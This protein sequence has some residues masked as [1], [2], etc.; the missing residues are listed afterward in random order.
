MYR[1]RMKRLSVS[2]IGL[3]LFACGSVLQGAELSVVDVF[4]P[5]DSTSSVVVAGTILNESTLGVTILV[6]I[7][8]RAGNV[9][10][11]T[12]TPSPTAD[13]T[14]LDDPWPSA[15]LFSIFDT[16]SP[17]FSST[18]N[19]AVD[20]NGLLLPELVTFTGNMVDF[21]II[22]S[23]GAVGTW[24]FRLSTSIGNS[25]WEALT[26]TLFDGTIT[27]AL[28]ECFNDP[29]CDDGTFCNGLE[30]CVSNSCVSGNDPCPGQLCDEVGNACVDCLIDADCSDGT[31]CNG[32]EVC[33]G[34]TCGAGGDPCSGQ[35]CD[36]TGDFCF[37]C[38]LDIDCNDSVF[39]N[40]QETCSSGFCVAGSDP[41]PNQI[42]DETNQVCN[43]CSF[44]SECNDGV[45]CNGLETCDTGSCIAGTDPCTGQLCDEG[46]QICLPDAAVIAVEDLTLGAGGTNTLVI[47]GGIAGDLTF[48]VTILVEL[49]SR[50]GNIGS[51]SYTP[52]PP[53]DIAQLGDP[54]PGVG[55][56][57]TFDA[58]SLG[59]STTLNGS[60]DDNGT[61]T[62]API[63]YNDLLSGFPL[64][65]SP[66]A[67][68]V[69]DV[70]LNTSVGDSSWVNITTTLNNGTI[71]VIPSVGLT[72]VSKAMPPAAVTNVEVFGE[73]NG[74]S[75]IGVTILLEISPRVGNTGS[76][77]FTPSPP[78]DI[79]QI[80][81]PWPG[82]GTFSPFDTDVPGF[83]D[84]LN[85]SVDDNGS[86][87]FGAVKFSSILTAFPIQATADAT[88]IW[89]IRLSTS[90]GDSN[91]E[92]LTTA[93]SHG[94]IEIRTDA[95]LV[96][97]ECDDLN[98]CTDDACV[99][100][101]CQNTNNTIA[102]DDGDQCTGGDICTLGICVG[103]PIA[104]GGS[105]DDGDLCTIADVC[106]GGTC[107]GSPK[108]C[109][110]LDDACNIGTCNP[111]TGVCEAININ[112][113]LNCDDG[114]LCTELDVCTLGVCAGTNLD[115]TSFDAECFVGVCNVSTGIC[116]ASQ[117][118]DGTVCDDAD[119][120][121]INDA[122]TAG[123]CAGTALD[124]SSLDDGCIVGTCNGTTGLCEAVAV[125][126]GDAC[127]DGNLCTVSDVCIGGVCGG[128]P[129]DCTAL[130]SGCSLGICNVSTGR[131]E[132]S[133]INDG[134]ICDDGFT[135]TSNDVCTNGFCTGTL[136]GT[137]G[138]D[139]ALVPANN[140]VLVD[141]VIQVDLVASSST[142]SDQPAAS[143]EII[144]AWNPAFL[145]LVGKTDRFD[146]VWN[147]SKFPD[148]SQLDG[149]N[150]PFGDVPGNDGDAYYLA[151][152]GFTLNEAAFLTEAGVV[153]TTFEFLA[154]DGVVSTPIAIPL[155]VGLFTNTR[156]LG[157]GVNA[158][159]NITGSIS[160]TSIQ[161][162][163]CF[164]GTDCDDGNICTTDTCTNGI[165]SNT[166]NTITCDD[167]IFCTANDVCTNGN[168]VGG[169]DSCPGQFCN[170]ILDACV[171][172]LFDNDCLDGDVCTT[173][174]CNALGACV[175]VNNTAVCDDGLFCTAADQC[176]AGICIGSGDRCPGQL[177]NESNDRCV[178][179]L[180]DGDCDDSNLCTDD[181]C[182][183]ALGLCVH[184]SNVLPCNDGLFCSI[185]DVCSGGVC[186][187]TGDPCPGLLCNDI[188]DR[189]VECLTNVDCDDSN[190]CTTDLC[191]VDICI[192]PNNTNACEDGLFC[193]ANDR[194]SGGACV[195]GGDTCPGRLCDEGGT[196]CV[197]CFVDIECNDN[198][199][200]TFDTCDNQQGQCD[201]TPDD[202]FCDDNVFCNGAETCSTVSDCVN[203]INPC[204]DPL[205]CDEFTDTCGCQNP[206]V[207]SEGGRYIAITPAT[208]LTLVAL[209]VTGDP[210]DTAVSCV[211]LYVQPDG[212]LGVNPVF[213][214]PA[215]WGTVHVGDVQ[216][217][218]GTTYQVFAD[219]R[220]VP[221]DPE[222]LSNA[223]S[224]TTWRWGDVNFNFSAAIDDVLLIVDGW[225]GEF[226]NAT[227][228]NLDLSGC[229]TDRNVNLS[230]VLAGV[231]AWLGTSFPCPSPCP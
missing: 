22:A 103:T 63:T 56:F 131:C 11:V 24:D 174:S 86:F 33:S 17:G 202:G 75:T 118:T 46:L 207:V 223:I 94:T 61:L 141:S 148:D 215:Q 170:E 182:N 60:V 198:I 27:V 194:C 70:F 219:C 1:V 159:Q 224:T 186:V 126:E 168:C 175:H 55:T 222:N 92:G 34:G 35:Q 124:C 110:G 122:C 163:E 166:N 38:F 85:G 210:L 195:P 77:T 113:G 129:K 97:S 152:A 100:G 76:L 144:I 181:T 154:L 139:L 158:G 143:V 40:G 5:Q 176:G 25:N 229:N 184:T 127:N 105:C 62:E 65:A 26:T 115:C 140:S 150:A 87:T 96:D 30:T 88:G 4:M 51:V 73:I 82:E 153:V 149:L 178:Q 136:V 133:N 193:T 137:P 111:T 83:S 50:P 121:T 57:T 220:D 59:F 206:T 80:G 39:C 205:L 204:D 98:F 190:S 58:D 104:E 90:A 99:A 21:P 138:V 132:R 169:G 221:G 230:D 173:D 23:A 64:T 225:L 151:F 120:C 15:G 171:E 91:W 48:G 156:V 179:C 196:R 155:S 191:N 69:W 44:N 106:N 7:T 134:L 108:D 125:N 208:G 183:P 203:A 32:L 167:G 20:D 78:S 231:D 74:E 72:V 147:D 41:C 172:C 117:L 9:G 201:F 146:G 165:C 101:L 114:V 71:T 214:T 79:V 199:D 227:L 95:C 36:E 37:D 130:N 217:I 109:T 187:G 116:E 197:D 16:D 161:V 160:S 185:T 135:C 162:R 8:T 19:G 93:L 226:S 53:V 10:T 68:G 142:C 89:D 211:S 218:P 29:D 28:A 189:C 164:I 49:V 6:E 216:M 192:N 123:T 119:L 102:C 145:Q 228:F 188:L 18:I 3:T 128:S 12:F 47:S 14:Q 107:V 177:C 66:D 54:W 81:D 157:A 84:T 43:Q 67:G 200:C 213:Q 212:R 42:C 112:E 45:F 13:I 2:I 180:G 209:L 52:S 31:F